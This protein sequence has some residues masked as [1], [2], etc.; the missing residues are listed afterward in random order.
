[1]THQRAA[2]EPNLGGA[3]CLCAR[4]P[5]FPRVTREREHQS[6]LLNSRS[7]AREQTRVRAARI[8]NQAVAR[9]APHRPGTARELEGPLILLAAAAWPARAPPYASLA[10]AF[11]FRRAGAPALAPL[12]EPR[13]QCAQPSHLVSARK[14]AASL[15]APVRPESSLSLRPRGPELLVLLVFPPPPMDNQRA[16]RHLR[17][18]ARKLPLAMRSLFYYCLPPRRVPKPPLVFIST[19][20]CGHGA[21]QYARE[22]KIPKS[23]NHR[24]PD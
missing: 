13:S 18:L 9:A 17:A 5:N 20:G 21:A 12:L 11:A 2:C 7:G 19:R 6:K 16:A 24:P 4:A 14:H 10:L 23:I 15:A 8:S 22:H 3:H 1:M